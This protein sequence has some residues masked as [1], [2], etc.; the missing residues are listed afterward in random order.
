[1][2]NY[3]ELNVHLVKSFHMY[4]TVQNKKSKLHYKVGF[5]GIADIIMCT[6]RNKT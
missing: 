1:M 3:T 5:I 6:F 2:Q 4:F